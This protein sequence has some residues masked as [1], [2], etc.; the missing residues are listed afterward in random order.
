MANVLEESIVLP[1]ALPI[2]LEFLHKVGKN[3]VLQRSKVNVKIKEFFIRFHEAVELINLF[4]DIVGVPLALIIEV[5][6]S[7]NSHLKSEGELTML[8]LY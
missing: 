7:A 4:F 2:E 1:D 3:S 8:R 5:R 6:M